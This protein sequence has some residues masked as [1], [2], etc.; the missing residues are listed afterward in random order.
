[1]RTR[2]PRRPIRLSVTDAKREREMRRCDRFPWVVSVLGNGRQVQ[3]TDTDNHRMRPGILCPPWSEEE[4]QTLTILLLVSNQKKLNGALSQTEGS[5][6][7]IVRRTSCCIGWR[8]SDELQQQ[9]A[10]TNLV[11][12]RCLLP[13]FFHGG[14][15]SFDRCEALSDWLPGPKIVPVSEC[16]LSIFGGITLECGVFHYESVSNLLPAYVQPLKFAPYIR[17]Y[18]KIRLLST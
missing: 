16:R 17:L 12:A 2:D 14:I 18:P 8:R 11:L 1:V 5:A 9:T 6:L 15:C 4:E 13:R 10:E 3:R 7:R